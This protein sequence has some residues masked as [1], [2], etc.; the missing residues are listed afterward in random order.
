[1]Q[2]FLT[3][4]NHQSLEMRALRS[5]IKSNFEEIR[6]FLLP[7]PGKKV[8][9]GNITNQLTDIDIDFLNNVKKLAHDLF[10]PENLRSKEVNGEYIRADD[11]LSY[12]QTFVNIFN[13]K[14]LP[15]PK[16]WLTV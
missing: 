14:S 4:K 11:F 13:K 15:E 10:A 7:Y 6:G 12:L 5:R 16:S 3:E 9:H 1:M 8:T 2:D